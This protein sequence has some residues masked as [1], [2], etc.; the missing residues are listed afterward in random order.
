MEQRGENIHTSTY[1]IVSTRDVMYSMT[2][3]ANTAVGYTGKFLKESI[4]LITRKK[5]FFLSFLV[6]SFYFIS[7]RWWMLTNSITVVIS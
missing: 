3:T 2:S 4:L 6:F 5:H 7:G 1:K